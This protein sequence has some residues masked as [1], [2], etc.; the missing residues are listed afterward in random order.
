MEEYIVRRTKSDSNHQHPG[1]MVSGSTHI[2]QNPPINEASINNN[3]DSNVTEL[4]PTS[5]KQDKTQ[6]KNSN[7]LTLISII[8]LFLLLLSN[9]GLIVIQ[10]NLLKTLGSNYK[11]YTNMAFKMNEVESSTSSINETLPLIKKSILGIKNNLG[12]EFEIFSNQLSSISRELQNLKNQQMVIYPQLSKTSLVSSAKN[13]QNKNSKETFINQSK[14]LKKTNSLSQTSNKNSL[15][16]IDDIQQLSDSTIQQGKYKKP[17][18]NINIEKIKHT[19]EIEHN[20]YKKS[21]Q[22]KELKLRRKHLPIR[23]WKKRKFINKCFL[24]NL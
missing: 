10:S 23:C 21:I 14:D 7:S 16:N 19:K 8:L 13:S 2:N 18:K 11:N 24:K 12:K 3:S 9:L 20:Q 1:E 17:E 15:D 6:P 5:S 22:S 4:Y